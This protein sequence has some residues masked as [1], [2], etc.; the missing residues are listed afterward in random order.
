MDD[1]LEQL[2][3]LLLE[4]KQ[5]VPLP[6]NFR[7]EPL[8]SHEA[9]DPDD[10]LPGKDRLPQ[11]IITP[12]P[13]GQGMNVRPFISC[14]EDDGQQITMRHLTD[15]L[16]DFQP[17]HLGHL[18]IQED[19]VRGVGGELGQR[20]GAAFGGFNVVLPPLEHGPETSA[21]QG[22]VIHDENP[23]P[24]VCPAEHDGLVIHPNL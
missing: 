20:L 12:S 23:G 4:L 8:E 24:V 14:E 7:L 15:S 1:E 18:D 13:K 2:L 10:Q 9:P 19:Q 6:L 3:P 22:I 21:R 17:I 5:A 11:E 16:T